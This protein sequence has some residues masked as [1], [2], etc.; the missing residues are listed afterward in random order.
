MKYHQFKANEL[1]SVLLFGFSSFFLL[2][3]KYYRHFLLLVIAAH[4][5]ESRN[6]NSD[7]L[8]QIK[9]LTT[10]FVYQFPPLYGDR[11]NVMCIH[12]IMHLA[13]SI[14]DF[15]G[16]YNYSTFNFENYLGVFAFMKEQL[17]LV[18]LEENLTNRKTITIIFNSIRSSRQ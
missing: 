14:R 6:I 1:R 16:V 18:T 7:Q 17:R 13:D 3:K 12:M 8:L 4:L 9:A 11:Q 15:G 2:P 10:E 5:S